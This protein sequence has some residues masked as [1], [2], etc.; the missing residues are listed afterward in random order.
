MTDHSSF[1]AP[2]VVV[3]SFAISSR[4]FGGVYLFPRVG[5]NLPSI[6]SHVL[7]VWTT[8]P[9]TIES[10]SFAALLRRSRTLCLSKQRSPSTMWSDDPEELAGGRCKSTVVWQQQYQIPAALWGKGRCYF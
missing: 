8:L 5:L 10:Y 7:M 6:S 3:F 4:N 9:E 2:L 1:V